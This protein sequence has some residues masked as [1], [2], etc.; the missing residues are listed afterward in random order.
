MATFQDYAQRDPQ[1]QQDYQQ[2]AQS[3]HGNDQPDW[4][5]FRQFA[6]QRGRQVPNEEPS[7][8]RD[9]HTRLVGSSR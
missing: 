8:L 3:R 1:I 9:M 5:S 7:D 4:Q 6:T 2:W